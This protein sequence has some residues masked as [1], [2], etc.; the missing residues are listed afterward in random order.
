MYLS[1]HISVIS[2]KTN[3][4]IAY[5]DR[6]SKVFILCRG[7]LFAGLTFLLMSVSFTLRAF[8]SV[9]GG[10]AALCDGNAVS[11][12]L[13]V[14][15]V[16]TLSSFAGNMSFRARRAVGNIVHCA[17]ATLLIGFAGCFW[18][19]GCIVACNLNGFKATLACFVVYTLCN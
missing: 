10:R 3:N 12:A 19:R 1:L 14:C 17:F 9:F 8:A 15:V 2:A 5:N 6:E 11:L 16:C 7:A 18:G 13:S 4:Y